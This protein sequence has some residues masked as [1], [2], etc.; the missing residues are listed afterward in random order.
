MT[1][2]KGSPSS[3]ATTA[4]RGICATWRHPGQIDHAGH[5]WHQMHARQDP[6]RTRPQSGLIAPLV[7]FGPE[8]AASET[9]HVA[10]KK[11]G[12]SQSL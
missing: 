8:V 11:S 4:D 7:L 6:T 10:V 9:G 1:T 2:L 5:L 3:A 12:N